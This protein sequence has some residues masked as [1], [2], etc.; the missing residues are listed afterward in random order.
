[1][2]SSEKQIFHYFHGVLVAPPRVIG[3]GGDFQLVKGSL[4][5]WRRAYNDINNS[6][7]II[8]VGLGNV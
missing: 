3:L 1:M 2:G 5:M 8:G 4:N 6:V 7:P